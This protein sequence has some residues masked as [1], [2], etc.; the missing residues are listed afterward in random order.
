MEA[1]SDGVIVVQTLLFL[2]VFVSEIRT[3]KL[4]CALFTLLGPKMF[5][6][7]PGNSSLSVFYVQLF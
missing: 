7:A 3:K 1:N 6:V 5:I 2:L 4:P